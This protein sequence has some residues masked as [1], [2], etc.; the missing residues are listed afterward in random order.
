MIRQVVSALCT[1]CCEPDPPDHDEASDGPAPRTLASQALDALACN[2]A[3][4]HI[5]PQVGRVSGQALR[6]YV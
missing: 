2:C 3:S 1:M 5:H 4:M 6:A